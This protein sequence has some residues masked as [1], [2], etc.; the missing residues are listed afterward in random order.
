VLEVLLNE[1]GTLTGTDNLPD[2][3]QIADDRDRRI[4][5]IVLELQTEAGEFRLADVLARC[6]DPADAERVSELARRGAER[7]NYESMLRASLDRIRRASRDRELEHSKRRFL[8]TSTEAD[9]IAGAEDD[10]KVLADGVRRHTHFAPRRL[11]RQTS[12]P[13]PQESPS[14]PSTTTE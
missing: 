9:P 8:G 10:R 14:V 1:P 4:A 11:I 7:G 2:P 6:H 3:A 5:G 12:E 13:G